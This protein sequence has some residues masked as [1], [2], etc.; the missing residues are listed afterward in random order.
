MRAKLLLMVILILGVFAGCRDDSLGEFTASGIIEG[1]TVKVAAQTG[2]YILNI[3]FDEGEDAE[4][5][6]VLAVVD[7][8][9]LVYQLEQVEAALEELRV[10]HQINLNT[11]E[12]AQ[13]E[14][15]NIERKYRRYQ[16]LYKQSS[17]SKQTLDDLK[18]AYDSGKAQL[19]NARQNLR[20]V[21]SKQKGLEAQAKLLQRQIDDATIISPMSGTIT[22]KYYE[23]GET[24]P[25][26]AA[27]IEMINL[28]TMWTKV[29]ISEL[30][31]PKI[32]VGQEV[33]VRIDGTDELLLGHVAWISP[34]AEFTPKNIL[35]QE[36]RT[37]LVYAV[38]VN[39]D[40]PDKLLKHGM[41]V[42]VAVKY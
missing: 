36:S 23:A 33:E 27:I 11:L 25:T 19:Q 38:K 9:K 28:N 14:Y 30:F 32:K 24:I 6:L 13:S 37:S 5:G 18:T 2:G 41:P 29:Y 3:N 39:V 34:K 40:N 42:E 8:E 16:D 1:T 4:Q 21:E 7:T 15:D 20:L 35:T 31:L 12:K 10:Q 22:T 26:N 17:A